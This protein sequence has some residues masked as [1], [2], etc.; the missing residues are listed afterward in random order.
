[1]HA[2]VAAS[3][4]R[5]L[6]VQSG[7]FPRSAER[8]SIRHYFGNHTPVVRGTRFQRLWIQQERLRSPRTSAITSCGKD[9]IAWH[10][11]ASEMR[12]IV[13]GRAF[14]GDNHVR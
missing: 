4:F 1:V 8:L 12:H 6:E 11:A 13:E 7:E 14:A 5:Y 2:C 10:N 3:H 9:S